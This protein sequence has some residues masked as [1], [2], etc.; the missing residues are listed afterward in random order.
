MKR[1]VNKEIDNGK[2]KDD[3]IKYKNKAIWNN[4]V[5]T[6]ELKKDQLPSFNFLVSSKS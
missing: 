4:T 6:K 5:Y 2:N 3:G 1:Q